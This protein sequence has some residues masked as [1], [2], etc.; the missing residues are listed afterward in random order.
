MGDFETKLRWLS[1]RGNPLGPENLIHRIEAELAGDHLVVIAKRREGAIVTKT[2]QPLST[3]GPGR[4]RGPVWGVAIFVAAIAV[5]G[6]YVAF[7]GDSAP[8]ASDPPPTTVGPDVRIMTDLETIEAAVA[9]FYSGDGERAAEL[10]QLSNRT[11]DQIL[12]E[13]AYQATIGGRLN[14]NCVETASGTFSCTTPYHN[15]MTDAIGY[16]DGGDFSRVVVEDGVVTEFAFPVHTSMVL[17]MG[18]FLASEGRLEGYGNCVVGSF[19]ETC[20]T[21][22]MENLEAWVE[23]R[24]SE[25]PLEPAD[26][27]RILLESW[28]GGNCEAALF[29]SNFGLVDCSPSSTPSRTVEYEALLGAEISVENCVGPADSLSCEVH[30]SNV[31][32]V[33]VNKPP[34]VTAREF[35]LFNEVLVQ[36]TSG[37]AWYESDYPEDTELRDSFTRF[38]EVS[39]LQGEYGSEG[40]ESAHTPECA[41]LILDNL[42]AWAAWYETQ[43]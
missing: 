6:L 25:M 40:C 21:I 35:A 36:G 10:F 9:A 43:G 14:L 30:Y 39:G 31:M 18:I 41:T 12:E 22:Q 42:D 28:Y 7:R 11:D 3:K 8:V 23:W 15:A 20:A 17:N 1:E 5:V 13:S 4:N 38:A 24:K 37:D 27:V 19:P 33:A 2:Q 32:N 26:N 16:V 29:L 34:S